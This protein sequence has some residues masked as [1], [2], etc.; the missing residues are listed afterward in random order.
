MEE[1]KE[2]KTK[3]AQCAEALFNVPTNYMSSGMI[4]WILSH[5]P[6]ENKKGEFSASASIAS[7]PG[8]ELKF[9]TEKGAQGLHGAFNLTFED[10]TN[11]KTKITEAFG[12]EKEDGVPRVVIMEKIYPKLCDAE[13]AFLI[14]LGMEPFGPYWS[15]FDMSSKGGMPKDLD[16]LLAILKKM[17]DKMKDEL[18]EEGDGN[19]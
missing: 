6:D 19:G 3:K 15:H 8:P 1:T 16:D 9:I 10:I 18:G 5:L 4:K 13:K 12:D 7:A 14:A 11:L 17:R 2:V